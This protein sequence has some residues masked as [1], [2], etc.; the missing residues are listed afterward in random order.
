MTDKDGKESWT[1]LDEARLARLMRA[2]PRGAPDPAARA[3]AF[4][5]AQAE[6]RQMQS[7]AARPRPATRARWLAAASVTV[8]AL[9]GVLW[10][11]PFAPQ[12]A[13]L[14]RVYGSVTAAGDPLANGA[15]LRRGTTL[16]TAADSGA[17]LRYSPDLSL[18]LDAGTR[19]TL[20]GAD[21]L[22]LVSGRIYVA[23]TPGAA[24]PYV[25]HT[26]AGD[27]R[28]VG[29]RYVV[30]A[31]GTGLDVAVREGA[32]QVDAGSHRERAVAGEALRIDAGGTALRSVLADDAPWA[33]VD[34]LPTPI[35]I[36]GKSLA[37]FLRWYTAETGRRVTFADDRTRARAASAVLHGSVDGLPPAAALA[38]VAASVDLQA[39][40]PKEGPIV[41]EPAHH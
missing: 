32:V 12:V 14:E 25:V 23:V 17:L 19:V 10:L 34:K 8:I 30:R 29:T 11:Q 33:W 4:E 9:T 41:I 13:S 22:Q 35:V 3:R 1:E 28:H 20:D 15:R 37:E 27:V 16:V 38:I 26:A 2:V 21:R 39:V 24:V 6:W 18:R 31:R 7:Q 40:V 36:E 5:A